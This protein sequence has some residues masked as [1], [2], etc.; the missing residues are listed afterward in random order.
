[1]M[2]FVVAQIL[3]FIALGAVLGFAYLAAL[4]LNVRLYVDAGPGWF[5][6]LVHAARLLGVA[7]A[8]IACAHQGAPAFLSVVAGF[9]IMRTVALNRQTIERRL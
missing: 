6:L 9:Q 7:V 1:M 8:F 4:G 2:E 5:A 3:A